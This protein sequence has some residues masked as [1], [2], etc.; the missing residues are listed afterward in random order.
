MDEALKAQN[1][2]WREAQR[3]DRVV[4]R[5]G[6]TRCRASNQGE[7]CARPPAAGHD[8]SRALVVIEKRTDTHGPGYRPTPRTGRLIDVLA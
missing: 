2:A 4:E 3:R 5:H 8:R 1:E 7:S 6:P